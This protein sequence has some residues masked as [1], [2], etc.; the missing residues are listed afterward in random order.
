M[1]RPAP[2][3]VRWLILGALLAFWELMPRTGAIPELFLPSLS[4]TLTVLFINRYE[5]AEAL[6]VT[7]YEVAF[8]ML[9]ACGFGILLGAV[10][11][12]LALLRN[13]LLPVFSSLYAVPIVILYP[14]FTAWFGIGSES[15]IAFAGIYGFFPV[16]LST[17]AGIRT[18]EPQYVLAARSMGATLPQLIRR[19][20]IPASIPTV[21]TGLRLGGAL[22]I[23]GVV[24]S[25]MLT[26]AAG[27]GYL[28]TRYR[29]ILDSPHVFGAII[30]ILLLSIAFDAF[31]RAIERRT[32]VWQV[33]G[34]RQKDG[35]PADIVA[36]PV[37]AAV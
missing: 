7:I 16:M 22:T 29:T 18:I 28:V 26:S 5:Y 20:I 25:E 9:I 36:R 4:K 32:A 23:V 30:M 31:A 21:L 35:E 33:A 11:G 3:T 34:R 15:K 14:I 8:A 19:V 37:Q 24:V 10:I 12:G 1:R 27:I 6:V 17:A 13:L 2:S